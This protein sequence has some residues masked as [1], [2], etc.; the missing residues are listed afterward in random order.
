[1]ATSLLYPPHA[2][3]NMPGDEVGKLDPKKFGV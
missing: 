1:M 2:E 3:K